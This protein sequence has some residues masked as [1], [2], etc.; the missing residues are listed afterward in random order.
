MFWYIASAVPWYQCSSTRCWGGSVIMY[1]PISGFR[2]FQPSERCLSRECDLYCV[3]TTIFLSFEFRQF[4]SV[5]SII[6]YCPPNG[7]AGLALCRVRGWSLSP[8]P[9]AIIIVRTLYGIFRFSF[10]SSQYDNI[11]KTARAGQGI[12]APCIPYP[13]NI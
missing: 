1:S 12:C 9:P 10:F 5:K 6:L 3:R 13:F 8:L 11:N 4:D 7:T 2:K